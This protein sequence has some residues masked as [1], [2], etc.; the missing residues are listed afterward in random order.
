MSSFDRK[1]EID[2]DEQLLKAYNWPLM[3]KRTIQELHGMSGAIIY[4][5]KVD[6][7]EIN[8]LK[9]FLSKC[10]EFIN[11]WPLSELNTI[12][13]NIFEDGIVTDDE[14]LSLLS[15]L[16][17]IAIGP[18]SSKTIGG[19]FDDNPRI[20]FN[21]KIFMFT[22][23]LQF[24]KRKKAENEVISRGGLI[25]KGSFDKL[26]YLVVGIE[27]NEQ[28]KY[29][30]YGAKIEKV[31]NFKKEGRVK[32]RIIKESDFIKAIIINRK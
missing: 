7:N 23:K 13:K 24:G 29:S 8:L 14:R 16:E 22:G 21:G 25:S 27:G 15:F 30:R 31:L 3:V 11:E 4:D 18:D 17:K 1:L 32:T 9:S 19:L 2:T 20:D 28:W 10:N 6:D 12:L 26:N 5:K